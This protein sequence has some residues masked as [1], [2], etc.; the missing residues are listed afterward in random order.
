MKRTL[1]TLLFIGALSLPHLTFAAG[2][3]PCGGTGEDPCQACHVVSM[4]QTILTWLIGIMASIIAL[5]FAIGGMKMVMSGGSGEGIT[6]AKS[7]MTNSVIGFVILLAAWLIVDTVLKTFVSGAQFGTWHTIECVTQPPVTE[8][9]APGGVVPPVTV[10]PVTP[11]TTGGACTPLT[12]MTDPLSLRMEGGTNVIWDN[13]DPNLKACANKF[14]GIVGGSI[15]SAYRPQQYQ[16][17]LWELHDRWCTQHLS[18][19]TDPNCSVF[20]SNVS[21]EI[22]KHSLGACKLVGVTSNHKAGKA[23]DISGI[24]HGTQKV[25]NAAGASCLSWPLGM[26][27]QFH[28]ELKSGCSCQ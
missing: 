9:P 21:S 18:S 3:V 10:P 28:Y 16:T 14:I 24:A 15:T 25:L 19:N 11:P 23:V 2:F 27:D 4:G 26:K 5:V 20:K 6:Q 7:M 12:V 22:S 13:T 1:L 8:I 17:H